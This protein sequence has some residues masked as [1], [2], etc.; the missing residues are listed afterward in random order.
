LSHGTIEF[1]NPED[2][3]RVL[4]QLGLKLHAKN[5]IALGE[6]A[7]YWHLAETI[8]KLSRL[9]ASAES[10]GFAGNFDHRCRTRE[11]TASEEEQQFIELLMSLKT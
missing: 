1:R 10:E 4:E 8:R 9:A 6:S 3:S 11:L 2:L 5:R 7:F